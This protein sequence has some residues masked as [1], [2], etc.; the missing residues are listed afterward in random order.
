MHGKTGWATGFGTLALFAGSVSA[1]ISLSTA[2]DLA[3]RNDPRINMSEAAVKKAQAALSQTH[4]VYSPTII[5]NAGYGR[6]LGVPTGLPTVFTL[7]GESLVFN[8]S[9]KDNIRAAASGVEAAKLMLKDSTSQVEEDVVVTYLNLNSDQQ[10]LAALN[11]ESVA[12][13][14][15]VNIVQD[16]LDA[17]Q[18]T[19]IDLLK[20]KRTAKQIELDQL[21]L[22]DEITALSEH[23]SR[24]IG[25]PGN[26]LLAVPGS[27]PPLPGIDSLTPE[28]HES[29]GY[30]VQAS[31]A[32][33]R[34]KQELAF[35][36]NRYIGRPQISLDLNYSRIDTGEN[37]FTVYYPGFLNRSQNAE[38]IYLAVQIPI[39]D[40]RHRDE[41]N[42]ATA[43]ASR[44]RFEAESQ[45]NLF[46][47]ARA[48]LAHSTRE[49]AAR[50][51][52]A[53][54]DRDLA[55]EQLKA[56]LV[57][58][59]ANA[60]DARGGQPMT[61]KDEQKARLDAGARSV[62]LLSAQFDLDQA[63][64]NLLRQNGQLDTWLRN[65][66]LLPASV[67]TPAHRN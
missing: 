23:L 3:L 34:S 53:E 54:L 46:L 9:Q 27:I 41:A 39:F 16:R 20:S 21:Q 42:Q 32:N 4:D 66:S 22:Q 43:E 18:D 45:S 30:G 26:T 36:E 48:K 67:S 35:G 56:L 33:A 51:E 37:D 6:G 13:T 19:R 7:S 47:E 25:L 44:A 49:L 61:P 12:A 8:F 29:V 28:D 63:I 64:V 11:Q 65:S 38:S 52:L 15:L 31:V 55:Q 5:A 10:R 59:S 57:Q 58:L 1:Q 14:R 40:R 17:G 60:A 24:A 50:S 62:D 2:V